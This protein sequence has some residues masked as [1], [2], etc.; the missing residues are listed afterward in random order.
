MRMFTRGS[1]VAAFAFGCRMGQPSDEPVAVSKVVPRTVS[2]PQAWTL[3]DRSVSSGL[4]P[5]AAP[6]DVHLERE[7]TLSAIKVF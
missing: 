7:A 4:R 6:I 5:D 2:A 1:L 3:F